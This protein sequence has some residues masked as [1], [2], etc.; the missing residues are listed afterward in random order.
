MLTL[1]FFSGCQIESP[2]NTTIQNNSYEAK[3]TTAQQFTTGTLVIQ[4]QE[5]SNQTVKTQV[6][7]KITLSDQPPDKCNSP[8]GLLE[9]SSPDHHATIMSDGNASFW[10]DAYIAA[11]ISE[12]SAKGFEVQ[13]YIG[14]TDSNPQGQEDFEKA[15]PVDRFVTNWTLHSSQRNV[16]PIKSCDGK[17]Y[18]N[19]VTP[20]LE[21]D[22]G[23]M[24]TW[25]SP[26]K[27][28]FLFKNKIVGEQAFY[29][30]Q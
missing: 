24:G 19:V 10:G 27:V 29:F 2:K 30:Q 22:F 25:L 20:S 3:S 15:G 18:L 21:S 8:M 13:W 17:F 16:N 12:N 11:E 26:R 7:S 5:T 1:A 28:V 14:E 23:V 6:I 9:A 4:K